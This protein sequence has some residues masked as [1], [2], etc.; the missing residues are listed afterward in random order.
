MQEKPHLTLNPDEDTNIEENLAKKNPPLAE[1]IQIDE[2]QFT[3]E[4]K[5]QI[6]EF[7]KKSIL[8]IIWSFYNMASMPKRN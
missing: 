7:A 4:E 3:P 2:S 1:D 5:E 8:P 6:Q